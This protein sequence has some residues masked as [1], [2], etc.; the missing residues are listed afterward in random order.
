MQWF[1]TTYT[2][3]FNKQHDRTGHLFQG[4]YKSLIVE[5]EAY[6]IGLSCYIHRNPLRADIAKRL[7]SYPWSSYLAYAYGKSKPYWLS[8]GLILSQFAG[9]NPHQL[10]RQKVQQYAKE[11]A[12]L[13]EDFRH[14]LVFGS[15]EFVDQL[16]RRYMPDQSDGEIRAQKQMAGDQDIDTIITKATRLLGWNLE[17]LKQATRLT[18]SEKVKRD[19]LI[20]VLWQK[21]VFTNKKIADHF[22]LTHSSVSHSASAI[23]ARL[24]NSSDLK[25]KFEQLNSLFK[26]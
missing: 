22:G 21:G 23:R 2:L 17:Y 16:R 18:G 19:L 3:R 9:D 5:N 14:N 10:Y 6:L 26:V 15:R 4:R 25:A 7:A 12:N 24:Q 11:E 1:G 20:Y 13:W 8:T